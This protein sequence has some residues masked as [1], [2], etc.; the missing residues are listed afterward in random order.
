MAFHDLFKNDCKVKFTLLLHKQNCSKGTWQMQLSCEHQEV[1]DI[2]RLRTDYDYALHVKWG[3]KKGNAHDPWN[4]LLQNVI[5]SPKQDK[6]LQSSHH[7]TL[8]ADIDPLFDV[9]QLLKCKIWQPIIKKKTTTTTAKEDI[10]QTVQWLSQRQNFPTQ[11]VTL[12]DW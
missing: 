1:K 9:P 11:C 6:T 10:P 8:F 5:S 7:Y 12:S 4:W 2:I 3:M